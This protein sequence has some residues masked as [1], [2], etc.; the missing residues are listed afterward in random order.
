MQEGFPTLL[1]KEFALSAYDDTQIWTKVSSQ[2]LSG[3]MFR[4]FRDE[5]E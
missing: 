1:V 2:E 3:A 5:L 4:A